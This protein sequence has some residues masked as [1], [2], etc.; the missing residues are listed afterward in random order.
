MVPPVSSYL[1]P[2]KGLVGAICLSLLCA[3]PAVA[4]EGESVSEIPSR[5]FQTQDS[6]GFFWQASANGAVTSGETQYLQSGMNW[7]VD[8]KVFAPTSATVRSPDDF[9]EDSGVTLEESRKTL[10]LKRDLWID[11][12]RGGVR[13]LDTIQNSGDAA[14]TLEVVL[15]TTYP[16]AWQ[17][18]HGVDGELLSKEPVLNLA[19]RDFGFVVHFSVAE[20]RHDTF[21]VVGGVGES[22]R[23]RLS[24]SNNRRELS[25]TYQLVIPAGGSQSLLHWISQRSLPELE[26]APAVFSDWYARNQLVAPGVLSSERAAVANLPASAFP[27]E[28]AAPGGLATLLPLNQI[29]DSLGVVRGSEDIHWV[30][31]SNRISGKFEEKE[32]MKMLANHV[33]EISLSISDIAAI[34]GGGGVGRKPLIFMRNGEVRAGDIISSSL[35]MTTSNSNEPRLIDLA[36]ANLLLMRTSSVDG[37]APNGTGSMAQLMDRSVFALIA[38]SELRLP[39]LT[40]RGSFEPAVSSLVEVAHVSKP[41]PTHRFL[42]AK[43][44][45]FSGFLDKGRLSLPLTNGSPLE[46]PAHLIDRI[47]KAGATGMTVSSLSDEWLS[48][49]EVPQSEAGGF[50]LRG[51]AFLSASLT[52]SVLRLADSGAEIQ[53]E[54]ESVK[55]INR[56]LSREASASGGF[57]IELKNGEILR[58]VLN[59]PFISLSWQGKAIQIPVESLIAFQLPVR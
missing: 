40:S 56:D 51:N 54:S 42:T 19:D 47:W 34:R 4:A 18:L 3:L 15:R 30:S 58:G 43:G 22:L 59:D 12:K 17:S 6:N 27:V 5:F 46:I 14:V 29:L 8:G 48:L 7:I 50:L 55:S 33:G 24:A 44:S 9:P 45:V 35:A 39:V 41:F 1:V 20:G 10:A 13:T 57:V 49:E 32:P 38:E 16:F 53:I 52:D 31:A 28:S 25:L 2:Y 21:V 23:P 11:R 26:M 36:T 37:I